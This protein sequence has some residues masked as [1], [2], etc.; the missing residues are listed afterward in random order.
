MLPLPCTPSWI[1]QGQLYL[2]FTLFSTLVDF[3]VV[4]RN[5][6]STTIM[7]SVSWPR[8]ESSFEGENR[9]CAT[10]PIAYLQIKLQNLQMAKKENMRF[11]SYFIYFSSAIDKTY[12]KKGVGLK[13]G[14][15]CTHVHY[16]QHNTPLYLTQH[17]DSIF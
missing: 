6:K 10:T 11:T 1:A 8:S 7:K 13:V 17:E 16:T 5:S 12:A 9:S 2:C 4:N 15:A 14:L 3:Q